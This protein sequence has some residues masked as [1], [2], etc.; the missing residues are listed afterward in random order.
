MGP[1]NL[2]RGVFWGVTNLGRLEQSCGSGSRVYIVNVPRR[3]GRGR[4]AWW[5]RV[6]VGLFRH[7]QHYDYDCMSFEDQC[8]PCLEV[9]MRV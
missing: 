1:R 9:P 6:V 4:R 3:R 7:S 5:S 2:I 8:D